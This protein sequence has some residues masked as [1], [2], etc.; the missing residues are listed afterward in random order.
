MNASFGHPASAIKKLLSY[1]VGRIIQKQTKSHTKK[2]V[3]WASQKEQMEDHDW[4][5][6]MEEDKP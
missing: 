3:R 6:D 1:Q 5:K 2:A 4:N